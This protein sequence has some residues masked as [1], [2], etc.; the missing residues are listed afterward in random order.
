MDGMNTAGWCCA[1]PGDR[2]ADAVMQAADNIVDAYRKERDE[3]SCLRKRLQSELDEAK[4]TRKV[5]AP[6]LVRRT[7][8]QLEALG[9]Q[10]KA[11]PSIV[12]EVKPCNHP[13]LTDPCANERR[14]RWAWWRRVFG[15][16]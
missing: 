2:A 12:E 15:G 3:A 14:P 8:E 5:L 16:A 10:F 4:R 7:Q 9:F 1:P 6:P 11:E 13:V